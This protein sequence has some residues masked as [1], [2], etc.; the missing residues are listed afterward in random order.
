MLLPSNISIVVEALPPGQLAET[1]ITRFDAQSRPITRI[2]EKRQLFPQPYLQ[3]LEQR[4]S[5]SAA[6][7]TGKRLSKKAAWRAVLITSGRR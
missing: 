4:K 3:R 5:Y 7:F 2:E 1:Q 6:S